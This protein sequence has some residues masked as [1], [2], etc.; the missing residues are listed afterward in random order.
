MARDVGERRRPDGRGPP[1]GLAFGERSPPLRVAAT[2][3][4][5][6]RAAAILTPI[7]L[8]S[9]RAAGAIAAQLAVATVVTY[10]LGGT[11]TVPPHIFYVPVLFAGI[12]YGPRGAATIGVV[13]G[14]LAGPL[15]PLDVGSGAAQPLSDWLAR[16]GFFAA[17]G[18]TA[19]FVFQ[20][21]IVGLRREV[22]DLRAEH[23]LLD[24]VR[25]GQ[26]RV[27][28]QPIVSL[29]TGRIVGAEALVRWQ[30]PRRGLLAPA[31]FLPFARERGLL[32][33]VRQAVLSEA[34]K[35]GAMWC[36][37]IEGAEDFRVSVNLDVG[38]L[39][40]PMLLEEVAGA[41]VAN[42]LEPDRL[43]LE[44]TETG[45]I[46]DL[47]QSIESLLALRLLRVGIAVDDFGTG[48]ASLEYAQALPV[49]EIKIDR[50]FITTLGQDSRTAAVAQSVVHL[51]GKLDRS[52]VAEGV[53]TAEQLA[54][55]LTLGCERA[56]GF[57]FSKPLPS[58][59]FT[60]LLRRAPTWPHR[61]PLV[62]A[63]TAPAEL[64]DA[65]PA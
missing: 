4:D 53:E 15:M 30:H 38:E 32:R 40:N 59:E 37:A 58:R 44:I 60:T 9:T 7:R 42:R 33:Y 29:D 65:R 24:A 27:H 41:L 34:C 13:S 5:R 62:P 22:D 17:I 56:Q 61:S 31:E 45:L 39:T 20:H 48:Y 12:R 43:C 52:T 35:H 16:T 57:F 47:E 46:E 36:R 18:A 25:S 54:A 3:A 26:L 50:A 8:T 23:E 51:A 64:G 2:R 28:Y 63:G 19:A 1:T 10:L 55:L 6:W 49:D 11:G 21:S 14:L